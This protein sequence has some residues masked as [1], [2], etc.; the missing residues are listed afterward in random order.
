MKS[1]L[2]ALCGLFLIAVFFCVPQA[3]AV[4]IF[5]N[6]WGNV[7][8]DN[9]TIIEPGEGDS[10]TLVKNMFFLRILPQFKYLF[11]FVSI[12]IWT[13]Y[14]LLIITNAGNEDAISSNRKN[15]IWSSMGFLTISL[16]IMIGDVFAP[17]RA[18]PEIIDMPGAELFF[19]KIVSIIQ[20][21]LTPIAIGMIAY[22]GIKLVIGGAGDEEPE[23][24]KKMLLWGL[25]GLVIAMVAAP[26][27]NGVFYP[28]PD[29]APGA[30]EQAN[31]AAILMDVIRFFLYFLG[32]LVLVSFILAGTYYL[33]SFGD[34]ERHSKARSIMTASLIGIVII[35]MSF[36]LISAIVPGDEVA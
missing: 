28:G 15:L 27:V 3:E 14:V 16:A 33:T 29:A 1:S 6:G 26:L 10:V 30:E 23:N 21:F 2:F 31:F 19:Q 25:A 18:T 22:A 17:T 8:Q 13:V 24:A 20:L 36:V 5:D 32:I 11:A 34:E 9:N 4:D 12:L 35:L 7:F